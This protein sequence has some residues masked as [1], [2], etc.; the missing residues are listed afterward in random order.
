[1]V[2]VLAL[3]VFHTIPWAHLS[4]FQKLF[5]RLDYGHFCHFIFKSPR[6]LFTKRS[7][8]LSEDEHNT[9]FSA[10]KTLTFLIPCKNEP[11]KK[12]QHQPKNPSASSTL[13]FKAQF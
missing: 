9:R 7:K 8:L 12:P 4:Q 1:M 10:Q 13:N 5:N 6:S 2:A 3:Q 11:Q